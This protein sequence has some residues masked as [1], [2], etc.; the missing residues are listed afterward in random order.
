[1]QISSWYYILIMVLA[2]LVL[3][4]KYKKYIFFAVSMGVFYIASAG[5]I[6]F[7]FSILY[8]IIPYFYVRFFK[9]KWPLIVIMVAAF[10]YLKRYD[11]IFKT[12]HIPY[13]ISFGVFGLSYILFRIIDYVIN[14]EFLEEGQ[15]SVI[16]Y[17]NYV[18]SFYTIICGPIMNYSNF[19]KDFYEAKEPLD[20]SGMLECL[21]RIAGGYVKILLLSNLCQKAADYGF[22]LISDQLRVLPMLLFAVSNVLFIYFNFSGY[23]D[24]VIA[25]AKL[26]G[27][28]L[29]ENFDKPYLA[30]DISDFWNRQHATLTK[31]ITSYIFTPVTKKLTGKMTLDSA[32][33][34]GF[35]AAFLFAGLWHGTTLNYLVYGIL[36]AIGVCL[37]KLYTSAG[38]KKQGGRKA[39]R[40]YRKKPA[41]RAA[42][43]AVTQIY[44]A[45]SFMFIGYDMIGLFF[46][47]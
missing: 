22:G 20:R 8:I 15:K 11:W 12:A 5:P 10:L 43:I 35:F 18:L 3:K 30:N 29:P 42:E 13:L 39:F 23:C 40:E 46:G 9:T 47:A 38:I 16:D 4:G 28:K 27:F 17:L 6:A 44:I 25:F 45:L 41:V 7:L 32:Q 31:W 1:M 36:Q 37:T 24:V 34:F 14:A 19:V 26:A 2:P 21:D 33:Y